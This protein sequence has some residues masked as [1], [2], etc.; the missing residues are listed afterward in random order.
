[1]EWNACAP[2]I[3]QWVM[4]RLRHDFEALAPPQ[5]LRVHDI[6]TI[7]TY[8]APASISRLS[9]SDRTA[10]H[11]TVLSHAASPRQPM[12]AALG[13][14]GYSF[15]LAG[16]VWTLDTSGRGFSIYLSGTLRYARRHG[17]QKPDT[18]VKSCL[19]PALQ[20]TPSPKRMLRRPCLVL[21]YSPGTSVS[22][23]LVLS[24]S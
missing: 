15:G 17:H 13:C 5:H 11:C 14:R 22:G 7:R 18:I 19:P 12:H 2:F 20:I 8:G 9:R 3:L 4:K 1:M 10:P 24:R 23:Q 6:D 16:P 21:L